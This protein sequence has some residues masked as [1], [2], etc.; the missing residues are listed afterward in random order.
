MGGY[1]GSVFGGRSFGMGHFGFPWFP[2]AAFFILLAILARGGRKYH[3]FPLHGHGRMERECCGGDESAIEVLRR[4]F[5]EGR[6]GAEDFVARKKVLEEDATGSGRG[7][8]K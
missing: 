6:V 2:V 1:R 8:T 5:A 3:R 4:E 7:E